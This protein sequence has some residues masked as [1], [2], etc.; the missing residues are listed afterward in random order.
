MT[1]AGLQPSVFIT[2]FDCSSRLEN[3]CIISKQQAVGCDQLL[4]VE[5]ATMIPGNNEWCVGDPGCQ[6]WV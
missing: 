6:P 4:T 5:L 2:C 1:A 3:G